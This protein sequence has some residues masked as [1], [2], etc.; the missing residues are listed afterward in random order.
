MINLE[1]RDSLDARLTAFHS[2]VPGGLV[3]RARAT[4]AA[5]GVPA[6]RTVRRRRGTRRWLIVAV[7]LAVVILNGAAT[8]FLPLYANALGHVPGA[9][10][11]LQWT[12]LSAN[13]VTVLYATSEHDG[14]R[15][16]VSAGYADENR[17]LLTV[18]VYGPGN[19]SG[20]F[21]TYSLT[22]QFGHSYTEKSEADA[23]SNQSDGGTPDYLDYGI[24]TGAAAVVGARLTLRAQD[25]STVC[26]CNSATDP[27]TIRVPGV[28]QVTFV[29]EQH[30]ATHLTLPPGGV[31]GLRY[32]FPSVT[33]TNSRLVEIHVEGRGPAVTAMFFSG[34]AD[35]EI[36][37]PTLLDA[38][39]HVVTR[40][41]LPGNFLTAN[42]QAATA[43]QVLDYTLS[44]GRYRLVLSGEDGSSLVRVVIV[45]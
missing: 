5:S 1:A 38:N 2:E 39:G 20:V 13:D 28:W 43:Y 6:S 36:P 8:Y 26:A 11:L 14:V 34:K 3:D 31:V 22:D 23:V 24:I 18:E 44:P 29:L 15:L 41:L 37:L 16:T 30:D 4:A 35:L 21:E 9:A 33:I 10:A 25:W 40:M 17:T 45:P 7:A 42:E 19:R 27:N 32:T 12:G